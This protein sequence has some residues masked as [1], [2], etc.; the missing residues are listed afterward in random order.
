MCYASSS[1]SFFIVVGDMHVVYLFLVPVPGTS[2]LLSSSDIPL[3]TM[4][5]HK[6]SHHCTPH[7]GPPHFLLIT[8][9]VSVAQ[10]V[11]KLQ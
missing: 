10:L 5:C 4:P 3:A 11:Y 9:L 1:I 7:G 8:T 2:L 6:A